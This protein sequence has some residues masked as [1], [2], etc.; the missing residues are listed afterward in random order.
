MLAETD[1][2]CSVDSGFVDITMGSPASIPTQPD[3]YS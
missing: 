3:V 1:L 2:N